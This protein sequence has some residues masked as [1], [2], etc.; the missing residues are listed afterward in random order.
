MLGALDRLFERRIRFIKRIGGLCLIA[1]GV[2]EAAEW[3]D[4]L[5]YVIVGVM[6]QSID[7]AVATTLDMMATWGLVSQ[8]TAN[9]WTSSFGHLLGIEEKEYVAKATALVVE[10]GIDLLLLD[11]TW[12]QRQN[13]EQSSTFSHLK[14]DLPNALRALRETFPYVNVRIFFIGP[15]FL[16]LSIAGANR[17]AKAMEIQLGAFLTG[18]GVLQWAPLMASFSALIL[19]GILTFKFFPELVMGALKR[20]HELFSSEYGAFNQAVHLSENTF[21]RRYVRK[22]LG[23]ILWSLCFSVGAFH[24]FTSPQGILALVQRAMEST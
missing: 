20:E 5:V 15:I 24:A 16:G 8:E 10:L 2:H 9:R 23:D 14:R 11:L 17:V 18:V 19:V 13:R 3:L 6:D 4:H 1:M 7:A 21:Q 12:G 22:V